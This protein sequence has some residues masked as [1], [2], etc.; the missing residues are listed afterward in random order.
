VP[1]YVA[2]IADGIHHFDDGT[3]NWYLVDD[4]GRLT[5]I[6][7]GFPGDWSMFVA[8]LGTLG[9]RMADVEAVVL[10]HAHVDHLGIA[11]R[12]RQ[13]AGATVYVHEA[14]E[15]LAGSPMTIADSERSP[16]RYLNHAGTRRLFLHATIAR[17]PLAKGIRELRTFTDGEILEDA[18]GRP[19]VV[20]TPGHT[21]GHSAFLLP[22]RG[23]LFA[24]DAIVMRD[25]YTDRPGPCLVS[26]AATKSTAQALASLDTIAGLDA[27]LVLTGHGAPWRGTPREAAER[28]RAAG[29]S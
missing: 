7:A 27:E 23:I 6:D 11:E 9:R 4:G 16:L 13:Q 2:E 25:P 24:G 17:A 5:L 19:R 29:T 8:A 15:R 21:D 3:V 26:A 10:T 28:A 18:P 14:D 1:S 12:V 22:D 20:H